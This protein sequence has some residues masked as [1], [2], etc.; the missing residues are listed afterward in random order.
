[1]CTRHKTATALGLAL[2]LWLL[3]VLA[4]AQTTIGAVRPLSVGPVTFTATAGSCGLAV[5]A[6]Y[7]ALD[8]GGYSSVS[9]QVTGISGTVSFSMTNGDGLAGVTP[10]FAALSLTTA[11]GATTGT[12]TTSNGIFV[13]SV[14]ARY[15]CARLSAGTTATVIL[16]ATFGGSAGG[17]TASISI[18]TV[19][20]GTASGSE[21]WRVN[22]VSGCSA[23]TTD[24]DDANIAA[25]QTSG[26]GISLGQVF[27][28][29]SWRRQTVGTAGT[30][31]SQVYS[32]QG[33]AS[34]TALGVNVASI[35]GV[36][37]VQSTP[38]SHDDA[39]TTSTAKAP[40]V[41]FRASA[42]APSNV[43][44]S[45]DA[46]LPWALLSGAS[47]VQPSFGGV[48]QST[49]N[50]S[51][52]TG[53]P[54]VTIASD[55]TAFNVICSSGCSGGT[56]DA[57]DASIATGQ[58][59]GITLGLTQV[60]DGSVWRRATI[61]T[62]GTASAQVGTVQGIA[63]MTPLLV[64]PSGSV[65]N[66]GAASG[67]NPVLFGGYASAAA[68]S[69]VSADVDAVR[70]WFLRSGAQASQPT[71]AGV[72]AVANNGSAGTGVQRVTLASDSTGNIATIGTSVTPGVAA[73]NLGKAEDATHTSGDVGVAA[74]CVRRDSATSGAS[75]D[76]DYATCNVDANGALY[77]NVNNGST[78][79][80]DDG[81]VAA[82]QS[83]LAVVVAAPYLYDGTSLK[84]QRGDPCA[85]NAKVY[86]PISQTA[87]TQLITGTS[88]KKTYIC[89]VVLVGSDAENVSLVAGT[90]T[91]CATNTVAVIGGASAA[92]GPNLAANGGFT[93]GT[94]VAA[95]A[96]TTV[97]AD[98]LCLLQSGSGR[99]AGVMTS[100]VQ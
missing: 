49:G 88:S 14:P 30:A 8:V 28:G 26:L 9:V 67:V 39:I 20:Q 61:G 89:S 80:T 59:T 2:W 34:G 73:A 48:L 68:P 11:D 56:S 84:R 51:A 43:S 77:V 37:A 25:G 62:A 42:A 45:D 58:T 97:N 86:T 21:N 81:D 57:D 29:S 75:A 96:A 63:S 15:L 92:T 76:G 98:N 47:V 72:L 66:D 94:G 64:T 23:P 53:T 99:V 79:D 95:I 13:G 82:G 22:C 78:T 7:A 3:P 19:A 27:D 6:G 10:T 83:S 74:L 70:A 55:N 41:M 40:L 65:A 52:G 69:D 93:M 24:A 1:M 17:S 31:A 32:V 85:L 16:R 38:F 100:V 91:V 4:G 33:I 44:A 18:G 90:G 46:V 54:R 60:Y 87:G 5:G 50:G 12:S 35:S 71:F 36:T